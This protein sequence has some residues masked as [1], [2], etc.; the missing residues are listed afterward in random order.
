MASSVAAGIRETAIREDV[1]VIAMSTHDRRGLSKLI[2]GSV[3]EK[4]KEL[5]PHQVRVCKTCQGIGG[6][7]VPSPFRLHVRPMHVDGRLSEPIASRQRGMK[8][9]CW[10]RR[11]LHSSFWNK[12]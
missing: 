3:C 8:W 4:V 6:P 5:V 2:K 9:Y 7:V 10:N 1:D 12:L 11:P